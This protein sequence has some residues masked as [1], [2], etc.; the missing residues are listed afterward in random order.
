MTDRHISLDAAISV[1]ME[2]FP[3]N[4]INDPKYAA[5]KSLVE[6]LS[7]LP[8]VGDEVVSE[9]Y[10]L[11]FMARKIGGGRFIVDTVDEGKG[12]WSGFH[13]SVSGRISAE[14]AMM[15][16]NGGRSS[17]HKTHFTPLPAPPEI[18]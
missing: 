12:M 10:K 14:K 13:V 7:A 5:G 17:F 1:V 2:Y 4:T 11:P 15:S 18:E 9:L 3:G 8:A 6:A 16:G